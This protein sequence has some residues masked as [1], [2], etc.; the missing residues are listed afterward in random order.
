MRRGGDVQKNERDGR[1]GEGGREREKR[2]NQ[3]VLAVPL[4]HII[5]PPTGKTAGQ[6]EKN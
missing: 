1:R 4:E 2:E 6:A 3:V 5:S